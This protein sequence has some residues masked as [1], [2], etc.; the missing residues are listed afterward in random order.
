M[1]GTPDLKQLLQTAADT[2]KSHRAAVRLLVQG[3]QDNANDDMQ[4]VCEFLADPLN[5]DTFMETN[6]YTE[7][8]SMLIHLVL[9]PM[10]VRSLAMEIRK[11]PNLASRER[12]MKKYDSI[13]EEVEERVT[14]TCPCRGC[15]AGRDKATKTMDACLQKIRRMVSEEPPRS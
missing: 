12:A 13:K 11:Q 5:Q 4:G 2:A 15:V 1:S 14:H 6:V 8:A 7:A 3:V 9:V 10:A